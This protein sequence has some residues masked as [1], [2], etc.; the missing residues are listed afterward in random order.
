MTT[1]KQK[2]AHNA[3]CIGG[4][5]VRPAV[6]ML[7]FVAGADGRIHIDVAQKLTTPGAYLMPTRTAIDAAVQSGALAHAL[8]VTP[9]DDVKT[10]K[11]EMRSVLE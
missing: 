7:K 4:S 2:K 3:T 11:A 1:A 9:R 10:F 5:G 6:D 8:G